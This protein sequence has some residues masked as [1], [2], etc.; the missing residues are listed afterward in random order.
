[1]P[2]AAF[3]ARAKDGRGSG[4]RQV[5]EREYLMEADDWEALYESLQGGGDML[6]GCL[7]KARGA[8]V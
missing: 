4:G 3:P 5:A 2:I 7:A 1:L 8:G 6:N